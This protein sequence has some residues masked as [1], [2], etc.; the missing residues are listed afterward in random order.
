M[1]TCPC[2]FLSYQSFIRSFAKGSEQS[3]NLSTDTIENDYLVGRCDIFHPKDDKIIDT[4]ISWNVNSFLKSRTSTL[5]AKYW[6]QMQGYMELYNVNNAEVV[7][8]LL[9]TPPEL[10]E[11]E[12]VMK[13]QH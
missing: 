4:K 10:I 3:C 7:F 12:K 9:N 1:I 8:L 6:Y 11:R 5:S 2:R 13:K